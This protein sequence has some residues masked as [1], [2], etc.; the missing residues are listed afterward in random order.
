M[1]FNL[2][3]SRSYNANTYAEGF[4]HIEMELPQS[5]TP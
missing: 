5:T 1:S 3:V 2:P 4:S